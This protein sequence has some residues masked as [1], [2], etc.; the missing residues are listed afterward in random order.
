[1]RVLMLGLLLLCL[2]IPAPVHARQQ[3]QVQAPLTEA[4]LKAQI[5]QQPDVP[6]GYLSLAVI[7]LEQGRFAEAERMIGNALALTRRLAVGQTTPRSLRPPLRIGGPI[8]EPVKI[9][10]MKPIYPAEAL[11]ANVSGLV[12]VE[13]VIDRQGF[14]V[15]TKVL[16]SV[17]LLDQAALDAVSQWRYLPTILN[18]EP[19]EVIMT[20]IVNFSGG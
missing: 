1:M 15:E 17:D 3:Q 20:V 10:D 4:Q 9:T 12:I 19:V 6:S 14:V 18:G 13:A 8:E 11:Q 5:T 16:R 2:V 7:Y